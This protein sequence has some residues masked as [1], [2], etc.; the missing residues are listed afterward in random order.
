MEDG[1]QVA[2]IWVKSLFGVFALSILFGYVAF[3]SHESLS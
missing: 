2:S 3:L 1:S